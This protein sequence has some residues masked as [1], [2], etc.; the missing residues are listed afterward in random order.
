MNPLG[1]LALVYQDESRY[2]LAESLFRREF[3]IGVKNRGPDN[4]TTLLSVSNIGTLYRD[5]GRLQRL[6][7]F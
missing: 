3:D 2:E 5:E 7:T 4:P 6:S 1:N